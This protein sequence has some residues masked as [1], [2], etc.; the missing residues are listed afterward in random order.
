M[1]TR[2]KSWSKPLDALKRFQTRWKVILSSGTLWRLQLL[3]FMPRSNKQL[4]SKSNSQTRFRVNTGIRNKTSHLR[5][6][7]AIQAWKGCSWHQRPTEFQWFTQWWSREKRSTWRSWSKRRK[8]SPK[9][10]TSRTQ[11]FL[12]PNWRSKKRHANKPGKIPMPLKT[13]CNYT[14]QFSICKTP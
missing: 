10:V 5:K 9:P 11:I 2:L 14:T 4:L 3:R 8:K 6:L 12:R 13:A 1:G 7:I